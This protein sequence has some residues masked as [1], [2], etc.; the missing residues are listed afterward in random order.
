M[1]R[2][3]LILGQSCH[4]ALLL[5]VTDDH[6]ASFVFPSVVNTFSSIRSLITS[7]ADPGEATRAYAAACNGSL[8]TIFEGQWTTT[9]ALA[10][11][12]RW[13]TH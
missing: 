6:H 11:K 1:R 7:F 8:L 2:S 12:V 3:H 4:Q 10:K 9:V 13:I 5:E